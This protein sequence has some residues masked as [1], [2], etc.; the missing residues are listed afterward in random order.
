[1]E[2]NGFPA[3]C[4]TPDGFCNYTAGQ[5]ATPLI[6]GGLLNPSAGE[7]PDCDLFR[8]WTGKGLQFLSLQ[9]LQ[10]AGRSSMGQAIVCI[11][12]I[13]FSC[14]P[15]PERRQMLLHCRCQGNQ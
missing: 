6:S 13:G 5:A 15:K 2:V 12:S 10:S 4:L 14:I 9:S 7:Q 3:S 1:M 8:L 11:S